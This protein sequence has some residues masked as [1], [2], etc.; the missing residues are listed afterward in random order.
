MFIE[1]H[2]PVPPRTS[3]VVN[4]MEAGDSVLFQTENEA[5][6]FRDVMRYNKIDYTMRKIPC[7]GWRVW[8]MS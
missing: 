5:L 4:Q 2:I 6:R 8:R 1:K 7:E 3:D